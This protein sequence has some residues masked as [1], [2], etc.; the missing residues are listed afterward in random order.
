MATDTYSGKII[1]PLWNDVGARMM[2]VNLPASVVYTAGTLLGEVTATPGTFKA[3]AS[4]SSD[5]SEVPKGIL[6][7]D[8]ATDANGVITFGGAS[9]GSQGVSKYAQMWISGDFDTA[10]IKQS[11]AGSIDANA[12]TKLGKLVEGTTAAGILRIT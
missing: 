11:G 3:Y 9:G 7:E 5:G 8:C 2:N 4:G 10:E 12:V 6:T 1:Q